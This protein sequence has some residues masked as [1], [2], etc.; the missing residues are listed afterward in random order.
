M[1]TGIAP[2]RRTGAMIAVGGGV[3]NRRSETHLAAAEIRQVRLGGAAGEI[4]LE[5]HRREIGR[6]AAGDEGLA[7]AAV[8]IVLL[9]STAV[10]VLSRRRLF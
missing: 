3:G 1:A 9:A 7:L 8:L 6:R 5:I 10:G 2:V 4:D